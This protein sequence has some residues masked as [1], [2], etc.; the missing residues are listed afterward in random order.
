MSE[1]VDYLLTETLLELLIT[2]IFP[3]VHQWQ[4]ALKNFR[5]ILK[6]SGNKG[7]IFV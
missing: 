3:R 1:C 7:W 2:L 4:K 6:M 5:S